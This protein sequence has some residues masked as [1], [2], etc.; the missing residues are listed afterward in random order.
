[1]IAAVI[2]FNSPD[3]RLS[4]FFIYLRFHF[5]T[6]IDLD[7]YIAFAKSPFLK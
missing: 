3:K 6:H 2:P 4:S 7:P 1:M 5:L